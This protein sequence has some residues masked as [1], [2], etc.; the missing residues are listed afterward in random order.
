MAASK[1]PTRWSPTDLYSQDAIDL[2]IENSLHYTRNT[3]DLQAA[4]GAEKLL[5]WVYHGARHYDFTLQNEYEP[6][7]FRFP[8]RYWNN[9]DGISGNLAWIQW[10]R[11]G[12]GHHLDFAEKNSRYLMDLATYNGPSPTDDRSTFNVG[13]G[14]T[15]RAIPGSQYHYAS[16]PWGL[17]LIHI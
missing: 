2:A 12:G 8:N 10:L 13:T 14:A 6:F 15:N 9:H 3:I 4:D 16:T 7:Q 5:G 1:Q 17:S 11:T